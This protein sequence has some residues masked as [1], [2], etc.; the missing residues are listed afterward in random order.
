MTE[1]QDSFVVQ[2]IEHGRLPIQAHPYE[3]LSR[4]ESKAPKSEARVAL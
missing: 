2:L 1:S 4:A 3:Q